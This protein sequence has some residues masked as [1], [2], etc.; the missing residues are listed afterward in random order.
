MNGSKELFLKYL[1]QTSPYPLGLEVSKAEGCYLYDPSGKKYLDLISGF[2]VNNLGHSNPGIIKAIHEQVDLYLHTMVYGELIQSPQVKYAWELVNNLPDSLNQVYFVN[3]G[4]EAVEGALKLAKRYTGKHEIVCFRNA[5][6][7]STHGALSVM[8]NETYKTAFRP[9]LP[10]IKIIEFNNLVALESISTATAGVIIEPIQAEAGISVAESDFFKALL[11]RCREVGA[12][13]IFDEIQTGF[14]R[15]G[16]LFNFEQTGIVPD[17][18][19]LAKALGGGMPLGAFI[20]SSEIM[21]HLTHN[22]ALGHITTFGG[23]PVCCAAGLASLE[24]LL[25]GKLIL[26]ANH[27]EK[28]IRENLKHKSILEIRGKGLLLAAKLDSES[29]V[30]RFFDLSLTNGLL[31]DY[32]L[33]CKDSIR[34]TPPLIMTDEET[35]DMCRIIIETLDQSGE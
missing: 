16:T 25:E 24:I 26:R 30:T 29:R 6:H 22:P 18:L 19:L 3:S 27:L 34:I 35:L 20:A 2:S 15:T 7:G 5:Y 17:I 10:S 4:S 9:L 21:S 33:F 1:G 14:G 28:L 13:L 32:F 23:H 11:N 12:L 31:F 8:G